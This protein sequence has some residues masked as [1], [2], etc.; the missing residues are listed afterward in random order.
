MQNIDD[1]EHLGWVNRQSGGGT[2]KDY[3]L[4]SL[5]ESVTRRT[6]ESVGLT[7]RAAARVRQYLQEYARDQSKLLNFV[8]FQTEPM[9]DAAPEALLDF[10]S[11]RADKW[12][13]I[14][15]LKANPIPAG[16]LK[17]YRER[18][19]ARHAAEE[20]RAANPIVWEGQYDDVYQRAMEMLDATDG[21]H[22]RLAG[23]TAIL[24][25]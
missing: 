11:C 20:A 22:N 7:V 19:A 15:P 6:L 25:L 3:Q 10:S 9:A 21:L 13:D 23:T 8:Y 14:K 18:I 16:A 5:A 4:Y 1:L 2:D 12:Q 24:A 17:A